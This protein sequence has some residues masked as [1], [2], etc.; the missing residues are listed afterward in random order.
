MEVFEVIFGK[1]P[2]VSTLTI[3]SYRNININDTR[4]F[5]KTKLIL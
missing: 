2:Y 3:E 4:H 1:H 5:K